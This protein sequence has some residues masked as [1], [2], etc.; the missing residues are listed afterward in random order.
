M[1]IERKLGLLFSGVTIV[2]VRKNNLHTSDGQP[3]ICTT[4][5]PLLDYD[6]PLILTIQSILYFAV[7]LVVCLAMF[8]S[9]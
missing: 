1:F 9:L 3:V 4:A 7:C 8:V 2:V 6:Q 5:I